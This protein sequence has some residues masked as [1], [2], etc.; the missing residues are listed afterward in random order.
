MTYIFIGGTYR[1]YKLF[2]SLLKYNH[3]PDYAFIL[4][5]DN[6]E[7][8]KSSLDLVKLAD[9]RQIP[10]SVKKKI[11]KN[12]LEIFSA[13]LRDLVIICGWRT[14]IP[15]QINEHLKLGMVAAHD[16]LLP[17]YRGFAPINWCIIN[18]EKQTGVTL[19]KIE[20]GQLLSDS[21]NS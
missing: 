19:F 3:I 17:A 21:K 11:T 13:K 14:I 12:D 10:Y 9:E 5:E 20:N 16:S 18:G 8:I 15:I 7:I 6:H 1:G 4:E 2:S